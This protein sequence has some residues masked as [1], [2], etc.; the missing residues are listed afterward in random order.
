MR[1]HKSAQPQ[2]NMLS[3]SQ[4]LAIKAFEPNVLIGYQLQVLHSKAIRIRKQIVQLSIKHR[5]AMNSQ[6]IPFIKVAE[7]LV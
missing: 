4:K 7:H 5:D 3:E 6:L 1:K 2:F